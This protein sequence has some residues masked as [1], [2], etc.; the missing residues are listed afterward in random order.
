MTTGRQVWCT[1][2]TA[3]GPAGSILAMRGW[4]RDHSSWGY[5]SSAAAVW[6]HP[7]FK[8]PKQFNPTQP[9]P[10]QREPPRQAMKLS[11]ALGSLGVWA[12]CLSFPYKGLSMTE[13]ERGAEARRE[14]TAGLEKEALL[15]YRGWGGVQV[16][17]CEDREKG[18][19]DARFLSAAK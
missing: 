9:N 12:P 10:T 13:G 6:A 5:G 16:G 7:L 3:A 2:A 1:I 18:E 4:G 17:I 8:S 15:L 14:A 11:R 19:P